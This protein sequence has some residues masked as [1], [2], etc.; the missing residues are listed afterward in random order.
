MAM[1]AWSCG[2]KILHREVHLARHANRS[3]FAL[4]LLLLLKPQRWLNPN[5]MRRRRS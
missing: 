5:I 4:L 2:I 3:D 1:H